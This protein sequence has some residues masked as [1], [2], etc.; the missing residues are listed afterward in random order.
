MILAA[1]RG[2]RMRPLTDRTPKPLLQAGGKPLIAYH[3][4]AVAAAGIRDVVINLAWLGEQ[5]RGFVEQGAA[6]GVNVAY[7]PEGE[8]G[9][10]TGGG[11]FRAL[12][13]LGP[14]PFCLINGDVWTDYPVGW[15]PRQPAGL[16][17]LVMV[18]NPPQHPRGDFCLRGG[19]ILEG[20]DVR[21]TYSGV[22]VYRPELFLDAR[23]GVFPLAPLLRG[24][25]TAGRLSGEYYRGRWVDVGTPDR[26]EALDR[27]LRA[28]S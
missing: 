12:S 2:E 10:E 3:L 22:G 24:A 11:I 23:P 26:L 16:A 1:G 6:W 9:L 14:E 19:R 8:R 4:E 27:Q 25:A 21:L 17:H 18:E 13:L 5:I 7:S 28:G 20:G 15:L